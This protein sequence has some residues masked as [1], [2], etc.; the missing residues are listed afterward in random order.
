M[1]FKAAD[2]RIAGSSGETVTIGTPNLQIQ[3]GGSRLKLPIKNTKSGDEATLYGY[4][5]GISAGVS[6]V[7]TPLTDLGNV[8]ISTSEMP[9][10]GIGNIY[11]RDISPYKPYTAKD[12]TGVLTVIGGGPSVAAIEGSI[13]MAVWQKYPL[14]QCFIDGWSSCNV[15]KSITNTG[16]LLN[17]AT[18]PAA[19]AQATHAIGLFAGVAA[20]TD[21]LGAGASAFTYN[22][23]V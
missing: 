12:F 14:A 8:T 13:C 23:S 20:T 19:V 17:P 11:R 2:W 4:G 9:S 16:L 15:I 10:D 18:I 3:I 6:L 21:L 22:M 1:L 7:D 5:G